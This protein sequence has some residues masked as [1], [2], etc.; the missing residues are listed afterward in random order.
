MLDIIKKQL[1]IRKQEILIPIRIEVITFIL[2]ILLFIIINEFDNTLVY[3]FELG[4]MVAFGCSVLTMLFVGLATFGENFSNAICMGRTR[5]SFISA[6]Y[7]ITLGYILLNFII[8]IAFVFIE[9]TIYAIIYPDYVFKFVALSKLSFIIFLFIIF[10]V[11]IVPTFVGVLLLK[12][13]KK[14]FWILWSIWMISTAVLP[15]LVEKAYTS[16]NP[17]IVTIKNS[18]ISMFGSVS[19]SILLLTG[20]VIL[21]A[22]FITTVNL[23]LKQEA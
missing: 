21:I 2:G 12:Y 11:L 18:T 10:T 19:I 3:S 20:G 9:R 17:T 15:R 22:M 8:C 14:A 7:I 23:T 13:G 6:Y 16:S 4:S 1:V 5:K